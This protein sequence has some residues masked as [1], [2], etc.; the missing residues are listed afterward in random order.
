MYAYLNV[1]VDTT[2]VADFV[3]DSPTEQAPTISHLEK[4]K[5]KKNTF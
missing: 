5:K 1:A 3:A 2:D 4:K